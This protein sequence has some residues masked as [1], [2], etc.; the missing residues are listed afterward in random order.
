MHARQPEL[1][2][3]LEETVDQFGLRPHLR[4]GVG[5]ESAI[6]AENNYFRLGADVP[7]ADV[8]HYW[9]G[10]RITATGSLVQVAGQRPAPVDLVAAYNGAYDPDLA[11]DAGWTP[12]LRNR[13][14]PAFLVPVIVAATAGIRHLGC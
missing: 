5:V 1:Q 14:D 4:L 2:K 3:Y 7:A 12:V 8:I 9:K 6:Y 11:A 10:T 13:V